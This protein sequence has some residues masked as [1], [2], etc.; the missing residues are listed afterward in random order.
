MNN[1]VIAVAFLAGVPLVTLAQ[2]DE[3]AER[4]ATIEEVRSAFQQGDFRGLEQQAERYMNVDRRT[5]SGA[6]KIEQFDDGISAAM[7]YQGADADGNYRRL[8]DKTE[9]WTRE[10]PASPLAH[11]LYARAL[12]SYAYYFRGTGYANTVPPLAW[13]SFEKYARQAADVLLKTQGVAEAYTGWHAT[14]INAARSL[15]WPRDLVLKV[16][17]DGIRRNPNDYRLYHYTLVYLMPK[18]HGDDRVVS[19]FIDWAAR[20][21]YSQYGLEIYARLYSAAG[22]D[23]YSHRLYTDSGVDWRRMNQG[24]SDWYSKYPTAWNL[25]I[26]AYHA[27]LANDK[28]TAKRLLQELGDTPILSIWEPNAQVMYSTCRQVVNEP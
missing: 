2:I 25:N 16:A 20:E 27:C 26:Y 14:V 18:W 19:E 24:L 13:A 4:R 10:F 17:S 11:V 15:G 5:S 1:L 8:V 22:Q 9:A 7:T 28:Q 3:L 21:T 12:L 23:Q 6:F